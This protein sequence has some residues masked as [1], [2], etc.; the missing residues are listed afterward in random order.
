MEADRNDFIEFEAKFYPVDKDGY[1]TKLNTLGARLVT[2]ERLMRRSIVDSEDYP[3][4]KCHYIRVRDEV[5]S[6]RLS[7]KTHAIEGGLITDQKEI[8][9]EVSDY[10]KTIKLIEAM[11]FKFSMYQETLRET[12]EFHGAEIT[13]DTWPGLDT[14]SEIEAGSEEK[15]R[16]IAHLLN[17]NWEKRIITGAK[18]IFMKVYGLDKDEVTEKIKFITFEQN[19]FQ[20]LPKLNPILE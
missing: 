18:E 16:K 4:F 12:W 15:V 2:P 10:D 14:Y 11:G 7:A 1:R 20:D 19:P 3:Q 9:I 8:D 17:L 5:D 6:I 13:I